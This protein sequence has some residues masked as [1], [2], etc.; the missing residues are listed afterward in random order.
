[1]QHQLCL[2]ALC[3]PRLAAHM[4]ACRP[5]HPKHSLSKRRE[6]I[7]AS[8]TGAVYLQCSSTTSVV[9][10]SA[11]QQPAFKQAHLFG[12]HT[13]AWELGSVLSRMCPALSA[14]LP[15]AS[16][17]VG[18]RLVERRR[19]LGLSLASPAF[20]VQLLVV[21]TV[22]SVCFAPFVHSTPPWNF[23][24]TRSQMVHNGSS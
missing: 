5:L 23:M 7:T 19:S 18:V 4:Q 21:C 17:L 22:T 1:M 13:I 24:Q 14:C 9:F 20:L 2:C 16:E 12:V 8:P 11:G 6:N 3:S 10:V 15:L